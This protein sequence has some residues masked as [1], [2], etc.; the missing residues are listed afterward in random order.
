MKKSVLT[1]S[2]VC[3]LSASPLCAIEIPDA[4]YPKA[5]KSQKI[6]VN[7]E[8]A[9]IKI[10]QKREHAYLGV[11]G[12]PV[13]EVI[14]EQLGLEHGMAL[15]AVVPG[16]PADKSGLKRNDILTHIG[17]AKISTQ[18][19]LRKAILKNKPGV[20]VE[21]TMLRRGKEMK[22]KVTLGKRKH[23][24][25]VAQQHQPFRVIP[26]DQLDQDKL[27]HL[28][29]PQQDMQKLMKQ[30]Q[31]AMRRDFPFNNGRDPFEMNFDDL[32]GDDLFESQKGIGGIQFNSQTTVRDGNGTV[33]IKSG[34]DGKNV[35]VTDQQGVVI[36]SG[37]MNDEAD[38]EAMPDDI[39]SRVEAANKGTSF[40]FK[41]G[42]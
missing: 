36:F 2:V 26:G 25:Q 6:A 21:A 29:L 14:A 10:Q 40:K 8:Q 38:K 22:Q 20:E 24:P 3:V 39:R 15:K 7:Q 12:D 30:M 23:A 31:D 35:T 32:F 5:S 13:D 1:S 37:P 16:S 27:R 9:P 18:D 19:D 4:K 42:R 41:L 28:N 11:M 34:K 17:K 33:T